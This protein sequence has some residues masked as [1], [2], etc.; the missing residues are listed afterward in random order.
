[1]KL[2]DPQVNV[3][4][5]YQGEKPVVEGSAKICISVFHAV[6]TAFYVIKELIVKNLKK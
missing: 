6:G 4:C 3:Y 5:D 2:I 1:M